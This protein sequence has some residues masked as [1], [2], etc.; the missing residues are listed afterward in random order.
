MA[1]S[2][3]ISDRDERTIRARD[4]CCVYCG[5]RLKRRPWRHSATIEHFNNNGPF[6]RLWN[7]AMCCRGCNSSKGTHKL[8][9]W[10]A[11]V[12]CRKKK[13]GYDSVADVVRKYLRSHATA[14]E[15]KAPNKAVQATLASSRA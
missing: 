4:K 11:S 6:T 3:G 9:I 8:S 7:I 5:V 15:R 13:I 14:H 12:Y 1:N 10:L 2:Y